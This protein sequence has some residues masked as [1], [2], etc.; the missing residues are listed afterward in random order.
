MA[1][2]HS[3]YVVVNDEGLPY[4]GFTVK[5][6][7]VGYLERLGDDVDLVPAVFRLAD[8]YERPAVVL[9]PRELVA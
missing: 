4:V 6:E 2:S 1:R 7:L 3:V 5:H 8:G 9:N